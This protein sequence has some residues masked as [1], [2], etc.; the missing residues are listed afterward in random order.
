VIGLVFLPLIAMRRVI[1]ITLPTIL[2]IVLSIAS[3]FYGKQ[4]RSADVTQMRDSIFL[5][6]YS[7]MI[8]EDVSNH[9]YDHLI[10]NTL[11]VILSGI[12]WLSVNQPSLTQDPVMHNEISKGFDYVEKVLG[13]LAENE[14]FSNYI[15]DPYFLA[16]REY[17]SKR[18]KITENK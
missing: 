5:I 10:G 4:S 2:A 12:D 16:M 8:L 13:Q 17:F 15:N 11:L 9:N 6:S 14:G 3:Y 18:S 1:K 7:C